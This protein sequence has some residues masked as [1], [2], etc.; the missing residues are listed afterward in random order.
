VEPRQGKRA[1]GGTGVF[2]GEWNPGLL[3]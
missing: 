2:V 1:S 3:G